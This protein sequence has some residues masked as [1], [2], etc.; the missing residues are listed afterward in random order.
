M[1]RVCSLLRS[2]VQYTNT[3]TQNDFLSYKILHRQHSVWSKFL[4]LKKFQ[5]IYNQHQLQLEFTHFS[6]LLAVFSNNCGMGTL[7]LIRHKSSHLPTKAAARHSTDAAGEGSASA[8]YHSCFGVKTWP[9]STPL[10]WALFKFTR[11]TYIQ[12]THLACFLSHSN[13]YGWDFY[14]GISLLKT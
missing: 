2:S 13:R 1:P 4:I 8:A 5:C 11:F 10:N 3:L 7:S 9:S 14:T 6:T 12:V